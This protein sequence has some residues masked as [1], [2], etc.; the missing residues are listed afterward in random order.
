MK[1]GQA[2]QTA[3][4][5][6]PATRVAKGGNAMSARNL[7]ETLATVPDGSPLAAALGERAQI[8]AL[9]QASHDAVLQP[10]EPGGLSHGERAALAAR[11]AHWNRD[12]TL[13]AHYR[14]LLDRTGASAALAAIASGVDAGE[15]DADARLAA[16]IRHADMLT[17]SPRD[18]TRADI[19]ALVAAGLAE[20]DIVRL[21]ELAAF[22]N[23][24]V[25][26]IAGLRLLERLK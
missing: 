10:R 16:I 6:E 24:Q 22:V 12:A 11:M 25:R 17:L 21:A 5:L 1:I 2:T 23:Y 26:V 4:A 3:A 18:A 9:S 13:A 14:E 8:M 7:I 15:T 19:E 20:P